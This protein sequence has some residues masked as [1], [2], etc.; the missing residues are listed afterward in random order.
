VT[1]SFLHAQVFACASAV[2][3]WL[4]GV[5]INATLLLLGA[6]GLLLLAGR[7]N[8]VLRHSAAILGLAMLAVMPLLSLATSWAPG[9]A[10]TVRPPW[11]PLLSGSVVVPW[12]VGRSL[13][14]VIWGG[15]AGLILLR[16]LVDLAALSRHARHGIAVP[17]MDAALWALAKGT[18]VRRRVRLRFSDA[19]D[20]PCT[21]GVA[22]PVIGM[23]R[24][25]L[26]W[27]E[28][29]RNAVFLHEL[30]HIRRW[31]GLLA[32]GARVACA[33]FWFHPLAWWLERSARD[34]AERACDQL[35]VQSG[36]TPER[37]ARHLLEIVRDA[38]RRAPAA[39]PTMASGSLG[40]RITTLLEHRPPRGGRLPWRS[41]FACLLA[42]SGLLLAALA[43]PGSAPDEPARECP[44]STAA[45]EHLPAVEAPYTPVDR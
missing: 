10:W 38:R 1:F 34:D 24:S 31:D 13:P 7:R 40:A 39:V 25:A 22:R 23:P 37:Y 32:A 35:V 43:G 8:P 6:G 12:S 15:V 29:R 11:R 45:E 28:E 2:W 36:V 42:A 17:R 33:L 16:L 5:L 4:A 20:I 18:G 26:S 41:L 44:G 9:S 14:A 3:P 27:T 21:W 19:F 30:G